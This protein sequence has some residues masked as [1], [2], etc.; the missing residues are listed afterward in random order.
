MLPKTNEGRDP[1]RARL[2]RARHATACQV[3]HRSQCPPFGVQMRWSELLPGNG[4]PGPGD[5]PEPLGT[6]RWHSARTSCLEVG[7]PLPAG[8]TRWVPGD[9]ATLLYTI[10]PG[11]TRRFQVRRAAGSSVF[12]AP[13]GPGPCQAT[14][15]ARTTARRCSDPNGEAADQVPGDTPSVATRLDHSAGHWAPAGGRHGRRRAPAIPPPPGL[16]GQPRPGETRPGP[17]TRRGLPRARLTVTDHLRLPSL[18]RDRALATAF[19]LL[20]RGHLRIGGEVY[21]QSGDSSGLPTLRRENVAK[22]NGVLVFDYTAKCGLRQ[23]ENHRRPRPN[24]RGRGHAPPAQGI[25]ELLVYRDGR[26]CGGSQHRINGQMSWP[27]TSRE[28]LRTGT[29]VPAVAAATTGARALRTPRCGDPWPLSPRP[30]GTPPRYAAAPTSTLTSGPDSGR[31]PPSTAPPT[32]AAVPGPLDQ[33]MANDQVSG[34]PAAIGGT[35]FV[36]RAVL[37]LLTG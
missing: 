14:A 21:A 23:T 30:W 12:I 31:E 36:E 37:R 1:R 20:D 2:H 34:H 8:V 19:R 24:R 26:P 28:D 33:R 3:S 9:G 6:D 10:R 27:W 32:A 13:G 29:T 22:R 11:A 7:Q 35:P 25:D 4:R 18:T 5:A 16:A 15:I 17:P